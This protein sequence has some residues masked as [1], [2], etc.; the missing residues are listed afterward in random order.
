MLA[1]VI[2][3]IRWDMFDRQIRHECDNPATIEGLCRELVR[4]RKQPY[5][6]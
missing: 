3:Q 5:S 6:V 2:S 4:A 1:P